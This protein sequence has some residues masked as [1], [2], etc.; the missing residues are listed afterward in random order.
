MSLFEEA[1]GYW[2]IDGKALAWMWA[3]L[4]RTDFRIDLC[5]TSRETEFAR[6]LAHMIE[7]EN[8]PVRYVFAEAPDILGRRLAL[9]RDIERVIYGLD[10]HRWAFGPH[11]LHISSAAQVVV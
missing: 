4:A 5:V 6:A 10:E 8:W 11:G 9:M 2:R 7:R 1:I 3:I